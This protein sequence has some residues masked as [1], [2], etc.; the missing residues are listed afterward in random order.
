MIVVSNSTVEKRDMVPMMQSSVNDAREEAFLPVLKGSAELL[1]SWLLSGEEEQSGFRVSICVEAISPTSVVPHRK[2]ARESQPNQ[3]HHTGLPTNR[4]YG[5]CPPLRERPTLRPAV[6]QITISNSHFS[7]P[8]ALDVS[9]IP[10][11]VRYDTRRRAT[12]T[13]GAILPST[14]MK[15]APPPLKANRTHPDA[16]PFL[17]PLPPCLPPAVGLTMF[18]AFQSK[19]CARSMERAEILIIGNTVFSFGEVE[20]RGRSGEEEGSVGLTMFAACQGKIYARN[21]DMYVGQRS[22]QSLHL[23]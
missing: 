5:L 19:I 15:D 2:I 11:R 10:P 8:V 23:L 14:T 7:T 6:F 21:M 13:H 17:L 16:A 22:G 4:L 12:G 1:V 20:A 9:H 18:A 3:R